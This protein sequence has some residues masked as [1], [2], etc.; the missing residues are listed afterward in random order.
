M[1]SPDGM[2]SPS[3]TR[4]RDGFLFKVSGTEEMERLV[5]QGTSPRHPASSSTRP[6]S[7]ARAGFE[8]CM[9]Y[10]KINQERSNAGKVDT[11]RTPGCI[12]DKNFN[13]VVKVSK[14]DLYDV[15]D[16]SFTRCVSSMT[17]DIMEKIKQGLEESLESIRKD[18]LGAAQAKEARDSTMQVLMTQI[19][20]CVQE[21]RQVDIGA[22]QKELRS[23][24]LHLLEG[25]RD[26]ITRLEGKIMQD[27]GQVR[28]EMQDARRAQEKAEESTLAW[29]RSLDRKAQES[30]ET[31]LNRLRTVEQL[32][33]VAEMQKSI[34]ASCLQNG[35]EIQKVQAEQSKQGAEIYNVLQEAASK[36]VAFEHGKASI[37]SMEMEVIGK[38]DKFGI[39]SEKRSN[40]ILS[41]IVKIQKALNVDFASVMTEIT[42]LSRQSVASTLGTLPLE[43]GQTR[44]SDSG[45][46]EMTYSKTQESR[47]RRFRDYFVQ[48]EV[49]QADAS[50]QTEHIKR[51]RHHHT[52]L[53][54]RTEKSVAE[55]VM[56]KSKTAAI[57]ADQK[58]KEN[59]KVFADAEAMKLRVRQALIKKQY[60][61]TDWYHRT[62]CAQAVARHTMF[63]HSTF[64]VIIANAIWIAVDIDQNEAQNPWDAHIV[65]QVVENC[66]C[67][68]FTIEILIRF[69]AFKRKKY[70]LRDFWFVFDTL[71]VLSMIAETWC[72]PAVMMLL[73]AGGG[74][75]LGKASILRIL[76]LAKMIRISRMVRLLRAFPEI[77]ILL[78]GIA[79]ATRS[80]SVFLLLWL[81]I[82]YVF[83][84]VF[85][86][87]TEGEA[88]GSQ[89]FSSVPAAMNTL[90]LDGIL[91]D[92]STFVTDLS[93]AN[94]FLWPIIL[95][96][97]LLAGV[98]LTYMLI[99]VLVDVVSVIASAEKEGM[100]VISLASQL[101][102]AWE[103]MNRDANDPISKADFQALL[104]EP[105][106][107]RIN[108]SVGIDVIMLLDM[109]DV[110]FEDYERDERD[111]T[112]ENFVEL[113]LTMRGANTVSIRDMREH[114][115]ITRSTV[116]HS[117]EQ[118]E[119]K[120]IE[121]CDLIKTE[122][123]KLAE[124]QK[125]YHQE[126]M[127]AAN[128]DAPSDVES[129]SS[130]DQRT[131]VESMQ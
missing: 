89:Y 41:E 86:Q 36:N 45:T 75:G 24:E 117:T 78:K 95:F 55:H 90:L 31:D 111:M 120:F 27:I 54:I 18:S 98:T 25:S 104:I 49:A 122:V 73:S 66:F 13:T 105:E 48:T 38:V 130:Y 74:T 88:I 1:A 4:D 7:A 3:P 61:V 42:S 14:R 33:S 58:A 62:G 127:D 52:M 30:S 115:K 64:L 47:S 72:L 34:N 97:I 110:V 79:A 103:D 92:A 11:F 22:V 68:Y 81:I 101:R 10:S 40:Q 87:L 99:G 76:R 108:Q 65:F 71:L 77:V 8:H 43:F 17:K 15:C 94:W 83:A 112:F 60:N 16:Q 50:I 46:A 2:R 28:N 125:K 123:A 102:A 93:R 21:S 106:I 39:S 32:T 113:M 63:E 12:N 56:T 119:R 53:K 84:V 80:V 129:K 5:K 128:S 20:E 26:M 70:C 23:S 131:P 82:I 67:S 6:V 91:P 37:T 9:D 69:L 118:I 44:T 35:R 19:H 121:E 107:C 29:I 116:T 59:R 126:A 114:L 96:F 85:R 100:T 109:V 124:A 57:I 51:P